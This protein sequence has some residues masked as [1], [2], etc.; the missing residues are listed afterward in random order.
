MRLTHKKGTIYIKQQDGIALEVVCGNCPSSCKGGECLYFDFDKICKAV[1]MHD[2]LVKILEATLA[3]GKQY[4]A[5]FMEISNKVMIETDSKKLDAP[6][7][8][9]FTIAESILAEVEE[10]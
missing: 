2:S 9:I 6:E 10:K 4:K 5:S 8:K 7:S 3:I 1:N